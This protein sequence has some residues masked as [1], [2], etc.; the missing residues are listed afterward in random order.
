MTIKIYN[1]IEPKKFRRHF[2]L[3]EKCQ[4]KSN[5]FGNPNY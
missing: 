4:P 5:G 3:I 1:V 2:I